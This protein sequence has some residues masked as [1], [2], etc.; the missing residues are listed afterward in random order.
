MKGIVQD[1]ETE[2]LRETYAIIYTPRK[3]GRKRY[4]Q[5]CVTEMASL[6]D[7]LEK[8]DT[9]NHFHAAKVCGP[10]RSSEGV[11]LYYLIEWIE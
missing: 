3:K 6:E 11:K 7:A 9:D 10:A 1:S 4:P 8:I 5:N 2:I